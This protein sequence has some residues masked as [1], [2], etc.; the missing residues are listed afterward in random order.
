MKD[1]KETETYGK[2][3]GSRN[4]LWQLARQEPNTLSLWTLSEDEDD[5]FNRAAK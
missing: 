1:F 5:A 4:F 3:V 2:L